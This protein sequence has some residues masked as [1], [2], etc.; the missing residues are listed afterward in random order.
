[1]R[2]A[3]ALYFCRVNK[4][5]MRKN[6][7][8]LL[9]IPGFILFFACSKHQTNPATPTQADSTAANVYLD[10]GSVNAIILTDTF[11]SFKLIR[12]YDNDT[13]GLVNILARALIKND[14]CSFSISFP[15]SLRTGI[16]Y[17]NYST[18]DTTS[19]GGVSVPIQGS[20]F[21]F[22]LGFYDDY[23]GTTWLTDVKNNF[24]GDTLVITTFDRSRHLL[25]GT[26]KATMTAGGGKSPSITQ[27]TAYVTG[28]FNTYFNSK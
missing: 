22:S 15:D 3:H 9:L 19:I 2:A 21:N 23:L 12:A 20:A 6:F 14:T 25:A 16:P 4:K 1:M 17:A 7:T 27:T 13:G 24:T 5:P 28:S 10:P 26:F 8:P 18:Q 11:Q